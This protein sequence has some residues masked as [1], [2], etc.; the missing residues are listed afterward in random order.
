MTMPEIYDL[1]MRLPESQREELAILLL[2]TLESD[3]PPGLKSEE[4]WNETI[5]RR[6]E[7]LEAGDA[8]VVGLDEAMRRIRSSPKQR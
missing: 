4:E 2:D 6:M 1:A 5:H 8:N 7:D 3:P